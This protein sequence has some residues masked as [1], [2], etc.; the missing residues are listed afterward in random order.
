[1]N[2]QHNDYDKSNEWKHKSNEWKHTTTISL[3]NESM[4]EI[5]RKYKQ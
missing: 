4:N 1:M 3:M 5:I 2:Y